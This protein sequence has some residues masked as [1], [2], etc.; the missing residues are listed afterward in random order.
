MVQGCILR[1]KISTRSAWK[2]TLNMH[3][4]NAVIRYK[5]DQRFMLKFT[6]IY[7]VLAHVLRKNLPEPKPA[8][9]RTRAI[10]TP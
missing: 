5:I 1:L 10:F 9:D 8:H 3:D 6:H 7:V 4:L 2:L